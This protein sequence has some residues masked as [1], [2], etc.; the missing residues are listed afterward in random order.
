MKKKM[1]AMV[2]V[3]AMTTAA[4]AGCGEASTGSETS[5]DAQN[6]GEAV[7]DGASNA[8]AE[9]TDG[10]QNAESAD[11]AVYKVGIVQYVDDAIPKPD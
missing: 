4:M 1:M 2:L 3:A 9:S 10:T 5:A 8:A 7:T 11:G 6:A